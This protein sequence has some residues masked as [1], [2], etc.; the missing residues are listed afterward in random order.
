MIV[1]DRSLLQMPWHGSSVC[2]C[3]VF[4]NEH[5]PSTA[6]ACMGIIYSNAL[7]CYCIIVHTFTLFILYCIYYI[8]IMHTFTCII[9]I[10]IISIA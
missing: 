9:I 10:I 3:E 2:N 6:C 8:I 1:G 5:L 7:L 4:M